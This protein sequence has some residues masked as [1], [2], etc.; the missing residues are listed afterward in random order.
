MTRIDGNHGT[1]LSGAVDR[2]EAGRANDRAQNQAKAAKAD[3]VEVSPDAAL[4]NSALQAANDVPAIRQD[5]VEA[6]RK[7]LDSGKLGADSAKL[8]DALIEHL[9]DETK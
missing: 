4:L 5:K 3:R 7:A 8:A 6:A 9:M 1:P 2:S